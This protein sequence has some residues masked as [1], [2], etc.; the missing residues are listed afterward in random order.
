MNLDVRA[1]QVAS[2]HGRGFVEWMAVL[3]QDGVT[4]PH[5]GTRRIEGDACASSGGDEP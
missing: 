3:E 4:D 1:A 5:Y 2:G